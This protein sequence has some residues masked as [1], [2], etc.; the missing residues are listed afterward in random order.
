MADQRAASDKKTPKKGEQLPRGVLFWW[1]MSLAMLLWYVTGL[2]PPSHP[3]VS[4][5]YSV[6]IAQV[7]ADNVSRL[8]IAGA[9]I[10]GTFAKPLTWPPATATAESL[11]K[12]PAPD[13]SSS[14]PSSP[15]AS[16]VPAKAARPAQ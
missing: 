2:W 6:F 12:T 15:S 4:I 14:K 13:Q 16:P 8:H 3:T 10:E 1:L 5:P 7:R 9:A 11:P